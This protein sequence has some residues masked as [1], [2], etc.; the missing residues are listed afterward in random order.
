MHRSST[1]HLSMPNRRSQRRPET[2]PRHGVFCLVYSPSGSLIVGGTVHANLYVWDASSG[3]LLLDPITGHM[4]ECIITHICFVT[5]DV[6]LSSADDTTVRQWNTRTGE[7]IGEVFTAHDE[8]VWKVTCLPDKKTAASITKRGELLLW[9][10]DT[11]EVLQEMHIAIDSCLTLAFSMDGTRLVVVHHHMLHVYD[12]EHCQPISEVHLEPRMAPSLLTAT[13]SPDPR[14][15][16]FGS[17]SNSVVIWDVD[18]EDFEDEVLGIFDDDVMPIQTLCSR[19]GTL[20]ANSSNNGKTHVWSTVTRE[21]VTVFDNSGPFAFSSDSQHLTYVFHDL[22]LSVNNLQKFQASDS[23]SWLDLPATEPPT[24]LQQDRDQLGDFIYVEDSQPDFFAS[25]PHPKRADIPTPQNPDSR[26]RERHR[27]SWLFRR[28]QRS[29]NMQVEERNTSE[30]AFPARDKNPLVVATWEVSRQTQQRQ[31]NR[32]ALRQ[33]GSSQTNET[34]SA[35]S[36][37]ERSSIVSGSH[38]FCCFSVR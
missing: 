18:K 14:K 31:N 19:D 10:L 15:I 9:R 34:S 4:A 2:G 29:Q 21:L 3:E 38:G 35:D 28:G 7:P 12:V 24:D 23:Q 17:G 1:S 20:V 26:P 25:L 37:D 33:R 11:L 8:A 6:I 22:T 16:F 5:E 13:F 30:I 36:E 27:F 32:T